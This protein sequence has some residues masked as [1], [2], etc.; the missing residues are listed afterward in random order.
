MLRTIPTVLF[1]GA[2]VVGMAAAV[3]AELPVETVVIPMEPHGLGRATPPLPDPGVFPTQLVLDDDNAEGSFALSGAAARQFM[4]FNSF[5][6]PGTFTLEE[7]WVL[8]PNNTD[9]P[10][11]GAV[12]LAVFH[13]PDDNPANGADLLATY[14]ATIQAKDGNTFS[15][16]PL[17]TTLDVPGGGAVLIGVIN[18]YF[19]TGDPP[20]TAPAALDTTLSQ[21]RSYVAIWSGDPPA[22]PELN[23]A[24]AVDLLDGSAAGNLMIRGFGGRAVGQVVSI[25]VLGGFGL[26]LLAAALGLAAAVHLMRRL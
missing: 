18:R 16:Y 19:T 10:L 20:P 4:W 17:A 22:S 5:I 24:L 2:L 6:N 9:V 7:I 26:V 14:D 12:Q 8:F 3:S 21:N 25:P 23:T 13:D 1:A 11:N 15:V